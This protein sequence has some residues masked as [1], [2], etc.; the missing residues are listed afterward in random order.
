[1]ETLLLKSI[2]MSFG[3]EIALYRAAKIRSS[4]VE[5]VRGRRET[6]VRHPRYSVCSLREEL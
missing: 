3:L 5:V 4:L 6:R 2:H 1:M